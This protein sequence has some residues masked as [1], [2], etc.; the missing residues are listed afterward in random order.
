MIIHT[1]KFI[2]LLILILIFLFTFDSEYINASECNLD[3]GF[4]KNNEA[5]LLITLM[6]EEELKFCDINLEKAEYLSELVS[7]EKKELALTSIIDHWIVNGNLDKAEK[8]TTKH[9][10]E[11]KDNIKEIIWM[12]IIDQWL[13]K[14]NLDKAKKLAAELSD[15]NKKMFL[16]IIENM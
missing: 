4:V 6:S 8:L 14:G 2:Y 5:L 13:E 9:S 7:D 16:M 12:S 1:K 10:S 15:Q 11:I 3:S